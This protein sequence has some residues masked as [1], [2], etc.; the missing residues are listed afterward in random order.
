MNNEKLKQTVA[1][2]VVTYNRLNELK[3]CITSIQNQTRRPDEI[4]VIDNSSSDGTSEWLLSQKDLTVITQTNSG[5]AGGQYTGVKLAFER[6]FDWIWCLDADVIPLDSCLENLL[7]YSNYQSIGFLTSVIVNNF[8]NLSQINIPYLYNVNDTL[9][10]I[11]LNKPISIITASF[12]CTLFSRQAVQKAGYPNPEFFLWG[13]D[14]E[15]SIRILRHNF[16]GYWI[17]KSQARHHDERMNLF[18]N[19]DFTDIKTKYMVRNSTYVKILITRYK[20]KSFIYVF[21]GLLKLFFDILKMQ[22]VDLCLL[23]KAVLVNYY[24]F[25]GILLYIKLHVNETD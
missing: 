20:D 25:Q 22:K 8:G 3:E 18:D 16:K 9:N 5:S 15:Y 23:K 2:V 1:A 14:V 11:L 6:G 19:L 7:T 4:I 10:S 12:G 17:I 13:D 21:L 24:M